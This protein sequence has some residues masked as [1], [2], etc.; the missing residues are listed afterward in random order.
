MMKKAVRTH[1]RNKSRKMAKRRKKSI[2]GNRINGTFGTQLEKGEG[3]G[4][5]RIDLKNS[6]G[7]FIRQIWRLGQRK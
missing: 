2:T 6:S 1:W 4:E 7:R 5:R 3:R